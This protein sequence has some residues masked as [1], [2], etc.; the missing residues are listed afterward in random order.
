MPV[1]PVRRAR[2]REA[3]E[4]LGEARRQVG[5]LSRDVGDAE[6]L[7]SRLLSD[8]DRVRG[9]VVGFCDAILHLRPAPGGGPVD[10]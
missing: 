10:E 7:H 2:L 9:D 6:I 4:R 8:M 5:E 1:D 3:L